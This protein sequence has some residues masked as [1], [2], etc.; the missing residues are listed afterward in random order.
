MAKTYR[1]AGVGMLPAVAGTYVLS[2]Y[3]DGEAVDLVRANVLGWQVSS[4]RSLVPLLIDPQACDVEPW[5]VQ[6]PDGR[7]EASDGRCWNDMRDWLAQERERQRSA[8]APR[9][10]SGSDAHPPSEPYA[11][12]AQ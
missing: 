10:I 8:L 3:F 1:P 5:F 12:A 11:A 7:V 4:E 9:T 2:A 6:H